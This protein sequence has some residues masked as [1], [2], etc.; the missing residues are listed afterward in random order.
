MNPVPAMSK[1][2]KL[3][4]AERAA[5]EAA[6]AE[7]LRAA[8]AREARRAPRQERRS[9]LW[10]RMRLWQ[11][12]PAF[13]RNREALGVLAVIVL[14]ALLVVYLLT[15]SWSAVIGAALFAIIATPVLA[16]LVLDRSHERRP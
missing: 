6:R 7:E 16:K 10:R 8:R 15:G 2:R 14:L 13:R 4:Q 11:H 12:G 3:A 1:A 5:A 9:L